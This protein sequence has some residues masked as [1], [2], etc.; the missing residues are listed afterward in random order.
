MAYRT[1]IEEDVLRNNSF[2][3]ILKTTKEMQLVLMSLDKGQ[4]IGMEKH[5][6]VTQFIRIEKGEA[7]AVTGRNNIKKALVEGD[8]IMIP[9]GTWHNIVAV[10]PVK[11]Y[12]LY[13][14]PAH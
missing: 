9:A 4:E 2:R 1:N 6:G 10:S 11:L 12:T 7:I 8:I 13:A 5:E 14:P 3:K